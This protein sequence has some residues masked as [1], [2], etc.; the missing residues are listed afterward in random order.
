MREQMLKGAPRRKALHFARGP[1]S[2]FIQLLPIR[3]VHEQHYLKGTL[4]VFKPF[5]TSNVLL[6]YVTSIAIDH[7]QLGHLLLVRFK[8]VWLL[9]MTLFA[10]SW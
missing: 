5:K 1:L 2:L 8:F 4:A 6:L 3:C 10:S 7:F 9:A